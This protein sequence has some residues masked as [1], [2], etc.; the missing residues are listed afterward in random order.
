MKII[1]AF[2]ALVC[3]AVGTVRAQNATIVQAASG[4]STYMIRNAEG[5]AAKFDVPLLKNGIR[6]EV[7]MTD[8]GEGWSRV[9]MT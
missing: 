2:L 4:G 3:A 9:R 5:D 7:R 8:A 6:P 1:T